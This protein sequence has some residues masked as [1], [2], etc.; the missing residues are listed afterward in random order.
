MNFY[1]LQKL[2]EENKS[3]FNEKVKMSS[4]AFEISLDEAYWALQE[5]LTLSSFA[6]RISSEKFIEKVMEAYRTGKNQTWVAH[7]LGVSPAAVSLR[8][9]SLR[10]RGVDLPFF[11]VGVKEAKQRQRE[12]QREQ[13]K[14]DRL[15]EL[16]LKGIT[17]QL[18]D[19]I[20]EA[21][22]EG[23]DINWIANE[24]G[25]TYSDVQIK[26]NYL[27]KKEY[28]QKSLQSLGAD[29]DF[30]MKPKKTY[31]D[32]EKE[33]IKI[34]NQIINLK[35]NGEKLPK[36]LVAWL[37][38]IKR[39]K[40]GV[41]RPGYKG[42]FSTRRWYPILDTIAA[43]EGF[44]DLFNLKTK[45]LSSDD[46]S[47]MNFVIDLLNRKKPLTTELGRWV[48]S[49]SLIKLN[50]KEEWHSK[51]DEIATS[52]GY[53]NLFDNLNSLSL[54]KWLKNLGITVPRA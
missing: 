11:Y 18:I 36:N 10:K 30:L 40:A 41:F 32:Y 46:W 29:V 3:A 15:M 16:R 6:K 9:R 8:I 19:K 1:E 21:K 43:K 35:K 49:Q 33:Y 44:P 22:K 12:Q 31:D 37:S 4:D 42:L 13:L 39:A 14:A 17:R 50:K 26:I 52:K 28:L 5:D 47:K 53:P 23:K 27:S 2:I 38:N 34:T 24:L 54:K 20:A 7:E 48:I 51:L 25:L 45:T